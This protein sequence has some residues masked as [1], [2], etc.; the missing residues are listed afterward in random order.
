MNTV[1][2]RVM[3]SRR[4]RSGAFGIADQDAESYLVANGYAWYTQRPLMLLTKKARDYADREARW[5]KRGRA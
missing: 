1:A 4:H 2:H 3:L 5:V